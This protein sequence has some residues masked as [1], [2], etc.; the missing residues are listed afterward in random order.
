MDSNSSIS[1]INKSRYN[2]KKYLEH[3]W[4]VSTVYDLSD[5]EI[6]KLADKLAST[7]YKELIDLDIFSNNDKV[8]EVLTKVKHSKF[9]KK[10]FIYFLFIF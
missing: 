7:S 5:S 1:K 6:E 9:F 3:E 4:D 8:K 10:F 2:L